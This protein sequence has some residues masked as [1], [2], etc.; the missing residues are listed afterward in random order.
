MGEEAKDENDYN[1]K[2]TLSCSCTYLI[3]LNPTYDRD[4]SHIH[5]GPIYMDYNI[6]V[7]NSTKHMYL[8]SS[9]WHDVDV[10]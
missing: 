6:I 4:S 3:S 5:D 9:Q 7:G 1:L 10:I 8:G 2:K